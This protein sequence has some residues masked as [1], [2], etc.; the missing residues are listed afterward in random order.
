L[1]ARVT[2]TSEAKIVAAARRIVREQGCEALTQRAVAAAVGVKAPSLYKRFRDKAAL[3]GAVRAEAFVDLEARLRAAAQGQ[4]PAAAFLRIAAAFRAFAAECPDLYR[5][6][7]DPALQSVDRAAESRA[8]APFEAAL[9]NMVGAGQGAS[10]AHAA[11]SLLH[12]FVRLEIDGAAPSP[13]PHDEAFHF[14]VF[15]LLQGMAQSEA[16]EPA[17]NAA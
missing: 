3:L 5:L 12:G 15:A 8:L 13:G 14:A 1:A 7:F 2:K 10:A 4:P 9:R 17:P 6:M 16:K 11:L